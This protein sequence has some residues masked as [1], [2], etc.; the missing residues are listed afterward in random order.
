MDGRPSWRRGA[1]AHI[2][3]EREREPRRPP[4]AWS[5]RPGGAAANSGPAIHLAPIQGSTPSSPIQGSPPPLK[6][7]PPPRDFSAYFPIQG[8]G[9]PA[10]GSPTSVH[11][12]PEVV[13]L[14]LNSGRLPHRDHR[15]GRGCQPRS[16]FRV[17][18]VGAALDSL[19]A[20]VDLKILSP[21]PPPPPPIRLWF[22]QV[23]QLILFAPL[24][25]SFPM[26]W[27]FFL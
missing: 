22:C 26:D 21:R 24:L 9:L 20:Q 12:Y 13:S 7:I 1:H 19:V 23:R 2:D 8:S 11:W 16:L 5:S 6:A 3:S 14:S 15:L 18:S 4:A 25:R 27:H 17:G 10:E